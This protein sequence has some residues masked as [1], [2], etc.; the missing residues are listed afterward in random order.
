MP[1]KPASLIE[2]G[3][4]ARDAVGL[5]TLCVAAAAPAA[6][7]NMPV[8][9]MPTQATPT[10]TMPKQSMPEQI[11]DTTETVTVTGIADRPVEGLDKLQ[12]KIQD[13]P[14]A[15]DTVS[16]QI[17]QQ[18]NTTRLQDALRYVPGVTLNSGE[19]GAH[20]DTVN[21]RGFAATDSFF[22]DGIR[23]PGAYAR[24]SFAADK[25]EV[26]QGP[27]AFLFGNGSPGGVV[28]Q[29][30]RTPSLAPL[31]SASLEFGT[32]DELRGTA[33]IN[34]PLG[35]TAALRFDVMGE[36]SAVAG[37]DDVLQKRWGIAPSF[38]LGIN[39]P[40]TFTLSWFHQVENDIP[41]YGIPFLDGAPAPVP[42]N[43]FYGLKDSDVTQT[44]TN[45]LTTRLVHRFDDGISVTNTLRYANYWGNFRVSA[46]HFG[47]DYTGGVPAPGTPLADIVVYRDRPS[48]EGTQT[49]LTDHVDAVAKFTTGPIAHTLVAGFEFG[50]QTNDIARFNNDV[51]GIDGVAP[52]PL[53]APDANT[54]AP[55]QTEIDAKP[56]DTADMA[57]V[58]ALDTLQFGPSWSLNLGL[59][60]DRYDTSADEPISGLHFERVD[61]KWSPRASIA[62]KPA[63]SQTY[64]FSYATAFD[65]PVSYLTLAPDSKAPAPE[66]ATTYEV[67]AK[68]EWLGGMLFANAA[69][70]RTETAN[71]LISDPDDPTLQEM[72]GKTQR[73]QGI[74][75]S[76]D[77][78]V[79]PEWEVE[80]NLTYL[81]PRITSASD[82]TEVGRLIPGAARLNANLWTS[83]EITDDWQVGAGLNWLG[84]RYADPGNTASIPSYVVLNAMASWQATDALRVQVNVAN[85]TDAYYYD[86]AYFSGPDES[87]V[88]PGAGRTATLGFTYQF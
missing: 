10:Q 45:I 69:L 7:Q 79:T 66:T 86:G 48:S 65:P 39:E 85:L 46:P 28:N 17:L 4:A 11:A 41:D 30:S 51:Q 15:I 32:N 21:L 83:Y 53:L 58:Y 43:L 8:Q 18:Q 23:D 27:S 5:A 44:E 36:R 70:F 87:H 62:Y 2:T 60:F 73:V 22:L 6:A 75:V 67:G 19:G 61:T 1:S 76:L 47:N 24:D 14:Q 9:S 3:L 33:D 71:A 78:H 88:I 20:G 40:T 13:T 63:E 72:P 42:R 34:Q 57:G 84:R 12:Q 52:T 80:A 37:R 59:R 50:R 55:L 56:S 25:I 54:P 74:E 82:P 16:Q 81:D 49:Y 29:V 35:D 31:A 26:L 38:S 77:G 68:T 64:Y